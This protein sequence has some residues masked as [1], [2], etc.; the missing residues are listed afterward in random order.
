MG[1]FCNGCEM[2]CPVRQTK[3]ESP[4]EPR[5][6][7]R[8]AAGPTG[9]T[10]CAVRMEETNMNRLWYYREFWYKI[11]PLPRPSPVCLS[12][13]SHYQQYIKLNNQPSSHSSQQRCFIHSLPDN[14]FIT[15][16][17][18]STKTTHAF[19]QPSNNMY[20]SK[21]AVLF[22]LAATGLSA[23]IEGAERRQAK[24]LSVQN[25]SQFQ[26]SDGTAGNALAEV[27]Q[28]FPVSCHHAISLARRRY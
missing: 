25:Y 26:V 19:R 23:P 21:I 1:L 18:H 2:R 8:E 3:K 9:T 24:L 4:V 14:I 11:L 5:R 6:G 15:V 22:T 27:A 17:I 28:K 20:F 13:S 10:L 7:Q 16:N 12:C